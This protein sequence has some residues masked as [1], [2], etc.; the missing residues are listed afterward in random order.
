M[1]RLGTASQWMPK[2]LLQLEHGLKIKL[3][4]TRLGNQLFLASNIINMDIFQSSESEDKFYTLVCLLL[5][6]ILTQ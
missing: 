3:F 6:L 1:Q 4:I 5:A 2:D